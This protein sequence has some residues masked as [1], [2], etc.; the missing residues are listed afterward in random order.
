MSPY[1]QR[2]QHNGAHYCQFLPDT[3]AEV[4]RS[5]VHFKEPAGT[6]FH[7]SVQSATRFI[8]VFSE[9]DITQVMSIDR[10]W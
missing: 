2:S 7:R 10:P 6:V 8:L 3:S 4:R 5:W 9:P 1:E